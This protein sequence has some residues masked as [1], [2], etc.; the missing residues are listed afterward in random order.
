MG[1]TFGEDFTQ[2]VKINRFKLAEECEVQP[3]VYAFYAEEYAKARADR[4]AEKDK[5]DLILGQREMYLRRNPPEDVKVTESVVNALL[6]QDT[7]VQDAKERFRKAQAKVDI[8]YASTASL[9][10]RKAMLDNL[11]SI[12]NK[13]YYS[14]IR[15][16]AGNTVRDSLNKKNKGE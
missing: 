6:I 5:L 9:E 4:D 14:N 10:H 2:D 16:D 13:E 15:E 8:L 1:I 7:E 3:S 12:W 11:V